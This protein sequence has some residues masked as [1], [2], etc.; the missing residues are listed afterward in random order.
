[1]RSAAAAAGG[2]RE[3]GGGACVTNVP[4]SRSKAAW[5]REEYLLKLLQK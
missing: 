3:E 4:L 1:M 2:R 5:A